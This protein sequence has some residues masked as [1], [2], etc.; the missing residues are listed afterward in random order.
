MV[1]ISN[2]VNIEQLRENKEQLREQRVKSAQLSGWEEMSK[3]IKSMEESL[4]HMGCNNPQDIE[5]FNGQAEAIEM[6]KSFIAS[7]VKLISPDHV[8][9]R[10]NNLDIA[11]M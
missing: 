4:S 6:F 3:Y 11:T 8:L 10:S 5:F 9:A 1:D 7:R 2:I